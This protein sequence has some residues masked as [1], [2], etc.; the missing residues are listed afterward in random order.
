MGKNRFLIFFATLILIAFIVYLSLGHVA[1]YIFAK[2][3][4]LDISYKSCGVPFTYNGLNVID[5]KTGM[6]FFAHSASFEPRWNNGLTVNFDLK[7]VHFIKK[8]SGKPTETYDSLMEL[9]AV[10]FHSRWIYK[11]I[12]GQVSPVKEGVRIR[13][14][15]AVNDEVT[16]SFTG[17]I[18]NNNTIKTDIK[19]YFS[20]IVL[21]KIPGELSKVMLA[22][23][24]NG[25]KSLSVH[26]EGN[27]KEPSIQVSSKRFRLNI[28]TIVDSK[29]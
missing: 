1:M 18:Y 15:R 13:D 23:E 27:Y 25:W 3:H 14:L 20:D 29:S 17:D 9:V 24:K 19:I 21:A 11:K 12:S 7:A 26:L 6:G 22:D 28:K 5:K 16:L 4:E 8:D 10:P 2:A